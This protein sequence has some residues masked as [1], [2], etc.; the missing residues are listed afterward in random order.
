MR[1]T[2]LP[3]AKPSIGEDAIADVADSIRSGWLAMGPKTLRFEREFAEYFGAPP[4]MDFGS[5]ALT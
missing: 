1:E 5:H 3:F 2:F 4:L